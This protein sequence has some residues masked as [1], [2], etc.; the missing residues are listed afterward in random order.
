MPAHPPQK[1]S[2]LLRRTF[3]LANEIMTQ[4]NALREASGLDAL[5]YHPKIQEWAA[6]RAME[7]T[8]LY[9]H[10][11]PNGSDCITVG[12]GL[13]FENLLRGDDYTES[14]KADIP[15]YAAD[16]ITAWYDSPSH[17]QS[18]LSSAPNLGAISCYVNGDN[19]YISHLFSMHTLYHMDYL[20]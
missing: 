5:L 2:P 1:A 11:R 6:I 9:S 19:V 7:I 13:C 14:W 12:R 17:R 4:V 8:M 16:V 18:M 10:T 15:G 20:I 3:A